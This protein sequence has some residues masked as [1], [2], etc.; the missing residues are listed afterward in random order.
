MEFSKCACVFACR[1]GWAQW[2]RSTKAHTTFETSQRNPKTTTE[3]SQPL[4]LHTNDISTLYLYVVRL[5][6]LFFF[7][8]FLSFFPSLVRS[9]SCW[10]RVHTPRCVPASSFIPSSS[11]SFWG[12]IDVFFVFF[13]SY[14]GS[15][16]IFLGVAFLSFCA[17]PLLFLSSHFSKSP[18]SG[19]L[20]SRVSGSIDISIH[21]SPP[22][23][24]SS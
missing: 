23:T 11:R 13:L 1:K 3:A 18:S 5:F 20:L 10:A 19:V 22:P 8:L 16:S 7:L 21:Q 15:I 14:L 24:H 4:P 2:W 6:F 9:L 17:S 12:V